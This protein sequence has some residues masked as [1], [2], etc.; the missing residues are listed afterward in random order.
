MVTV[1][2]TFTKWKNKDA[3]FHIKM[4]IF[5]YT[6]GKKIVFFLLSE[7][8]GGLKYAENATAAGAPLRTPLGEL[9]P[10]PQTP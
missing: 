6:L 7:A 5:P 4:P 3:Y 1:T 8:F 10:L 2:T 9:T